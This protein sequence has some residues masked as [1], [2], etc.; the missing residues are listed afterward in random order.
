[1]R[2]QSYDWVVTKSGRKVYVKVHN[3][4]TNFGCFGAV[5]AANHRRLAETDVMPYG[6][7]CAAHDAALALVETL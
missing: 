4:G 2:K 5:Y 1:M 3:V 6:L 7:R